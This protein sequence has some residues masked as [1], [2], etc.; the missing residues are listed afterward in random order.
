[1]WRGEWVEIVDLVMRIGVWMESAC[2][3]IGFWYRGNSSVVE[4]WIPVPAVGG[5]IPSSLM[6]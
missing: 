3:D 2:V 1:M 6:L 5:S 4:R